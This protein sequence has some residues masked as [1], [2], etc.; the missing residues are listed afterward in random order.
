MGVV[1][2][3]FGFRFPLTG[4][5]PVCYRSGAVRGGAFV[6]SSLGGAAARNFGLAVPVPGGKGLRCLLGARPSLAR[7]VEGSGLPA[8]VFSSGIGRVMR[9]IAAG[10]PVSTSLLDFGRGHGAAPAFSGAV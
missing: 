2:R 4:S 8:R 5:A 7:V 6:S 1:S 3:F 10:G 9:S